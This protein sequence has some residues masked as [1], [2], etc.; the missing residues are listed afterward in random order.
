MSSAAGTPVM[1][2]GDRGDMLGVLHI[3]IQCARCSAKVVHVCPLS[4]SIFSPGGGNMPRMM[5]NAAPRNP[6]SELDVTALFG[7]VFQMRMDLG[8]MLYM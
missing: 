3:Y 8:N 5:G 6:A 7:R 4:Y 2:C 1:Y